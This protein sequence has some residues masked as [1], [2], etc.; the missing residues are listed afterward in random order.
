M[1]VV[2]PWAR[3]VLQLPVFQERVKE[4]AFPWCAFPLW[5][6]CHQEGGPQR[7]PGVAPAAGLGLPAP[8]THVHP[9]ALFSLLSLLLMMGTQCPHDDG[10]TVSPRAGH[11]VRL[12]TQA[13][14]GAS[15]R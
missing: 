13:L 6:R 1:P 11:S 5:V 9:P 7:R 4:Q 12:Y 10:D 15:H 3:A 2:F 8:C 14:L